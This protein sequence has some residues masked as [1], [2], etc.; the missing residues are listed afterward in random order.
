MRCISSLLVSIAALLKIQTLIG[1]IFSSLLCSLRV[2]SNIIQD[3]AID[4]FSTFL[5][6]N[7]FTFHT[8][9]YQNIF[10]EGGGEEITKSRRRLRAYQYFVMC[11]RNLTFLS[12]LNSS[13]FTVQIQNVHLHVCKVNSS[14]V[15]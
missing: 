9:S 1:S 15:Q 5:F 8:K 2:C 13:T 10:S 11:I 12:V 3:K 7:D 6:E 14:L 4:D